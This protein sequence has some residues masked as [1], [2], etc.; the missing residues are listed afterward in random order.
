MDCLG[1][2]LSLPDSFL[3]SG[4]DT[5]G[6]GGVLQGTTCEAI[7]C[8]LVAAR[9]RALEQVGKHDIVKLVVY[10]SDQTHCASK[11]ACQIAGIVNFRAVATSRATNFALSPESVRHAM[12]EDTKS[13]LVP[14]FLCAMV[15]TTSSMAVDPIKPLTRVAKE[16]GVWV[17]VDA[18]YAASA[19]V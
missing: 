7:L 11:K 2:M 13:G 8:T 15:G 19:Y 14:L 12:A 4:N 3:F 6:G 9:D 16:F 10:N 17:H 5:T 18:A 1:R